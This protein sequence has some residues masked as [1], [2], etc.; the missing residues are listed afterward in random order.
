E[1]LKCP[2]CQEEISNQESIC[3]KCGASLKE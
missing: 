2:F 3:P 1:G